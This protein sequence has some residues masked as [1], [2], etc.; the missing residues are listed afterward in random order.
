MVSVHQDV[1]GDTMD[2]TMRPELAVQSRYWNYIWKRQNPIYL[3]NRLY[4]CGGVTELIKAGLKY[5]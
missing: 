4:L 3:V 5:W 1:T 2:I